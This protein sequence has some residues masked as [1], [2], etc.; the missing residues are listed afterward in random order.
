MAN[1]TKNMMLEFSKVLR[2]RTKSMEEDGGEI[3]RLL[4]IREQQ[5]NWNYQRAAVIR[6]LQK[7]KENPQASP[8]Q[9]AILERDIKSRPKY[10][11][12]IID[13]EIK[14]IKNEDYIISIQWKAR[15]E[16]INIKAS[17]LLDMPN[18]SLFVLENIK[19]YYAKQNWGANDS[20]RIRIIRAIQYN[21]DAVESGNYEESTDPDQYI[22][23]VEFVGSYIFVDI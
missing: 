21:I 14:L 23:F 13:E 20:N 9:I 19:D 17:Q 4:A 7:L 10:D 3:D 2:M 16:G 1:E 5:K 12:S 6:K 11:L 8:T 22:I 18:P 15:D